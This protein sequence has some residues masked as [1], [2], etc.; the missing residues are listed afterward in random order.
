MKDEP[1]PLSALFAAFPPLRTYA[2]TAVLLDPVA[3]TPAPGDSS[4][5]G[6]LLWPSAEPWPVCDDDHLVE[7]RKDLTPA[8]REE[9]ERINLRRAEQRR[10]TGSG[11]PTSAE[12]DFVGRLMEGHPGGALDLVAAQITSYGPEVPKQDV[13]MVPLVQVRRADVPG[14]PDGFWPGDADLLQ[15]LWCP[16]D[17]AEPAGQDPHY[18]GPTVAV[19]WRREDEIGD[20][21]GAVP[22]PRVSKDL[23]SPGTCAVAPAEAVDLPDPQELP[24]ELRDRVSQWGDD[25]G[26][27]YQ[28]TFACQEG[29]KLGG[30]PTWHL[31][32]LQPVDCVCGSAMALL[33]SVE[34]GG[35]A[36]V[37]PGT[38]QIFRC[39]NDAGHPVRLIAQ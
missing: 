26:Y 9:L 27:P 22:E 34:S 6:S 32:T 15:V 20:V 25:V 23:Y 35:P 18:Y 11:R 30:W 1:S 29:W 12:F 2:R 38:L 17:H 37:R 3:G 21:T 31:T 4:I 33:L 28:R 10:L 5:G 36:G 7:Y 13:A 16:N 8:E 39:L 24:A 19:R 14:T